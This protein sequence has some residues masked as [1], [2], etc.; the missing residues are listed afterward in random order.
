MGYSIFNHR[1]HKESGSPMTS[2]LLCGVRWESR[3]H[4]CSWIGIGSVMGLGKE[5]REE[6]QELESSCHSQLASGPCPGFLFS[7]SLRVCQFFTLES[8]SF[9]HL[10]TAHVGITALRLRGGRF[11]SESLVHLFHSS[12][13]FSISIRRDRRAQADN[14][15]PLPVFL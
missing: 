6:T 8:N 12:M 9:L 1:F 4:P 11:V 15:S 10:Y 14:C 3:L 13:A 5:G 7:L 2:W